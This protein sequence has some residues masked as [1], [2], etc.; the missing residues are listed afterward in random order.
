MRLLL[1][2]VFYFRFNVK[3]ERSPHLM[4]RSIQL[5]NS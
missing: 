4:L 2:I 3:R 1:L 5:V